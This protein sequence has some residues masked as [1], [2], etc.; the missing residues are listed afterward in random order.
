M[1]CNPITTATTSTPRSILHQDPSLMHGWVQ[2]SASWRSLTGYCT[3]RY[4]DQRRRQRPVFP[5]P[6]GDAAWS[7][8]T[9]WSSSRPLC[10]R[11]RLLRRGTGSGRGGPRRWWSPCEGP[12]PDAPPASSPGSCPACSGSSSCIMQYILPIIQVN[13]LFYI[14]V[15]TYCNNHGWKKLS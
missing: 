3:R 4:V 15:L 2:D 8:A 14:I 11:R 10:A 6:A 9:R 7:P 5:P 13:Y 1:Q 12:P